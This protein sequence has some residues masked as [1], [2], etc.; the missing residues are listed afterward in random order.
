MMIGDM[1]RG[2]NEEIS[3]CIVSNAEQN[4]SYFC[5]WA[6]CPFLKRLAR[7]EGQLAHA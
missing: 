7:P 2:P 3:V 1:P 4:L 5:M 6:C